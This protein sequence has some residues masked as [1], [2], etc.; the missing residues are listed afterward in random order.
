MSDPPPD[1]PT[2]AEQRLAELMRLVAS[3]HP[4]AQPDFA[5]GVVRRARL[6][7]AIV[8]PLRTLGTFA[9]AVGEGVRALLGLRR[10]DR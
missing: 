5:H 2:P 6:H 10:V 1:P 9:G 4:V 3:E 8:T 7:R